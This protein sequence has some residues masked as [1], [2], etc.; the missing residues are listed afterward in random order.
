M[1]T[2]NIKIGIRNIL[3]NKV[4][5]LISIVGLGVGLGCILLLSFLYIHENSF[6]R[7]IPNHKQLYRVI[8][9]EDCRTSYPLGKAVK[10]DN[11]LIN[12]FFRYYAVFDFELKDKQNEIIKED[13]FACA[14]ASIFDCLGINMKIGSPASSKSEV[15]ISEKIAE[16]YFNGQNPIGQLL[17]IRL[18]NQF[19]ELTISGVYE[20]FPS[21]STLDPYFIADIELTEEL[22]GSSKKML[23]EYGYAYDDFR[24]DWDKHSLST[25]LLLNSKAKPDDAVKNIQ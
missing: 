17:N 5:S 14:D 16:K 23:G 10:D 9:G 1:I 20:S 6:D 11:P 2:S 7:N 25:Y 24:T 13:N 21:N 8:H 18:N 15:T 19:I 3:N 22:F 4:H 12:N